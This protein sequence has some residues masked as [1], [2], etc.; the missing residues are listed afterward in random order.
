MFKMENERARKSIAFILAAMLVLSIGLAGCG[1]KKEEDKPVTDNKTSDVGTSKEDKPVTLSWYY[2]G[3]GQQEDVKLVEEEATKYLKDKINVN[4][5]LQCF[6]FGSY[7]DKMK[8]MIAAGEEFDI[9][10]TASW[11]LN[12]R[13][14]ASKGAYIALDDMFD[15]YAPKTKALV[16]NT[17]LKGSK[18][19]GKNYAVPV[20]KEKAAQYGFLFLKKYV[21]K[22]GFDINSLKKMEDIEPML[23]MIKEKEP[24]IYPMAGAFEAL[25]KQYYDD[26]GAPGFGIIRHDGSN[27]K[28][29]LKEEEPEFK[30]YCDLAYK[31]YK[32]GYIRADAATIKDQSGDEK[33]GKI[34]VKCSALKPGKDKEFSMGTGQEWIQVEMTPAIISNFDTMGAMHAISKTSKNPEK[35]L[36]FLEIMNNDKSMNNMICFGIEG[37]HYEKV[38]D[39]IIKKTAD[40]AKYNPGTS[41]MFAN[42]FINY[43]WENEDPNKWQKFEK[44]NN[45]A[46]PARSL[47]FAF[48]PSSVKNEIA[49]CDTVKQEYENALING[50]VD[51]K[52]YIPKYVKALKD[53]GADAVIA[54]KQK[55]IDAWAASQK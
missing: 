55:Q 51:P 9:C 11:G 13:E 34:F 40:N 23:K 52:V 31:F 15:K 42:N 28:I 20:N 30:A 8:T 45:D 7:P 10:F 54:E 36:E 44:F 47:G 4:L 25:T 49:A 43:L 26:L 41:W 46:I 33:A 5:K 16:G 27:Y 12:Y 19:D 38:S 6:D 29:V 21:D 18:V 22:Y 3:P 14:Q 37:V 17:F 1:N 24:G 39:N 35:A 53:A 2:P 32:A 48:E 50:T